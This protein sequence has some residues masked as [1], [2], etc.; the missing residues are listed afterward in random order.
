MVSQFSLKWNSIIANL[1][2]IT[3]N[4]SI[5]FESQMNWKL[6]S[7]SVTLRGLS[8]NER[9]VNAQGH[10]LIVVLQWVSQLRGMNICVKWKKQGGGWKG[11]WGKKIGSGDVRLSSGPWGGGELPVSDIC[12]SVPL[13]AS[14]R[15]S[16]MCLRCLFSPLQV[17]KNKQ[18]RRRRRNQI[19]QL[20]AAALDL[21]VSSCVV[22]ASSGVRISEVCHCCWST[23]LQHSHI[24]L[25]SW[26]TLSKERD[27][28]TLGE[29]E[30][31]QKK[32]LGKV[33]FYT[34]ELI[35]ALQCDFYPSIHL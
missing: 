4:A 7:K 29:T 18:K 30:M 3:Y 13:K 23:S 6:V 34:V 22:R 15:G 14:R 8:V 16:Y 1:T 31:L 35:H 10:H 27:F 12:L 32:V 2:Y 19:I 25:A 28:Y 20:C 26:E 24:H 21:M 5:I 33:L 9:K 11:Q 17:V